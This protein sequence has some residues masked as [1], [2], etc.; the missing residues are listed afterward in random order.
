[1]ANALS[2]PLK[3]RALVID[4]EADI[5]RMLSMCLSADGHHV[6]T[7][8]TLAEAMAQAAGR[9]FDL[10][11]LDLRLGTENGLDAI[12][13]LLASSPW[14]RVV[15]ITAYAA[16]DTA[17]EAMKRGASEYLP[18]PFTPAQVRVAVRKI[19]E[20][21]AL[22]QRSATLQEALA[23]G[24]PG[25]TF[26]TTSA[27]LRQAIELAHRAADG[28][29]C[30][31]IS[32]EPGIGKRTVARAIHAWSARAERPLGI[33]GC[34]APSPTHLESEWFGTVKKMPG[35][36]LVENVGRVGYCDGG[37]L[38][39]ED[40]EKLPLATQPKLLRLI[41]DREY[42]RYA[43]FTPRRADVRIIATT[44][45]DLNA[46]IADGQF[47]AD[48]AYALRGVAIDLPPLRRRPD[49]IASLAEQYLAFF[50][51]QTRRPIVGFEPDA[52]EA[53]RRHSWPGN[54]R[55][56]RNLVE[57]ATL[58]CR[59]DRIATWDFP[60]GVLNRVNAVSLGDPVSLDR[61]EELHIRGVLAA[62]PSID[63]AATIL[64]IDTVTLWRRR[65]QYGI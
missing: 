54:I 22:A 48:L 14:V 51:K 63:A 12:E 56:L 58:V 26:D 65:K 37:T 40:V 64:G 39:I 49:D 50:A 35:G 9:S 1:M 8:T 11:F 21:Q 61:I 47:R 18:K 57:R 46:R 7:A 24:G 20:I 23:A 25:I 5:C 36:N 33:A 41:Q 6:T 19:G 16:V 44:T 42:E 2:S 27:E 45:S 17:V 53:L 29:A 52:I 13:P 30:V 31:L 60:Q 15:V 28:T 55:E 3:L 62:A 32:G 43:D 10:V 59:T 4:D 38:L 34:V